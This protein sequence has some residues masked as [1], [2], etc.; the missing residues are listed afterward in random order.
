MNVEGAPIGP[1]NSEN[2]CNE[3]MNASG[4]TGSES[5]SVPINKLYCTLVNAYGMQG[6]DGGPWTHFG[7]FDNDNPNG[8]DFENPGEVSAL[9]A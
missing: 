8:E 4:F 5:G 7:Q 3:Q 9:K 6:P 1:G 2:G